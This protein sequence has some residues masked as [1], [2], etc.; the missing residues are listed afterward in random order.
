MALKSKYKTADDIPE[1]LSSFYVE[2]NGEYVLQVDGMVPKATVDDFRNNNIQ[3]NKELE[4]I[5]SKLNNVDIDEYR[6]LKD[7]KQKMADQELIDAGQLDKVVSDR[8]ERMRNDYDSKLEIQAKLADEAVKKAS[9]Y[10]QEFNSMIVENKLK[11][12]A[13]ANGVRSEALPD[14]MARGR[15][16]WKRTEGQHIAAFD[17]E[18]PIYGKK[19]A[20]PLSVNEWFE[21]LGDKAPHLFK[22]SSGSGATGGEGRGAVR[23]LSRNDQMSMNSN[24]E[25]IAAGKVT[26]ND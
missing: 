1:G 13:V 7:E 19:S 22:S 3:L 26:F 2:Q 6:Q 8:T 12:A 11:D 4:S 25:A 20:D 9:E 10:E 24:I 17:G 18:T 14:V 23:R 21:E 5:Q 15:K 16:V